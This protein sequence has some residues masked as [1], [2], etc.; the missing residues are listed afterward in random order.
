MLQIWAVHMVKKL[1]IFWLVISL[2][3][4]NLDFCFSFE[5]RSKL[6]SVSRINLK[7]NLS[8]LKIK[9][10][11]IET[12]SRLV[13]TTI[14]YCMPVALYTLLLCLLELCKGNVLISILEMS[15]S[16]KDIK[17]LTQDHTVCERT[18]IWPP[19]LYIF[20][21]I[22]LPRRESQMLTLHQLI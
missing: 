20:N 14:I 1:W 18:W 6:A 13:I 19:V 21:Y 15:F 2:I 17:W 5:I 4:I 12:R 7:S 9:A 8:S 3:I 16:Y 22:T 10:M 11:L